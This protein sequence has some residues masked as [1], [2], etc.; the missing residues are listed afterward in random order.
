MPIY[1]QRTVL[2][3]KLDATTTKHL[4]EL[5]RRL[6]IP[7]RGTKAERIRA[8]SEAH[9]AAE[10]IDA[11]IRELYLVQTSVE[12]Q[13]LT[14][15]ELHC[16]LEKLESYEWPCRQGGLDQY[17]QGNITRRYLRYEDVKEAVKRTLTPAVSSYALCSWYNTWST[18]LIEH[19]V[20]Q[21][22]TVVPT[23]K[24]VKGIDIFFRNQPFD[25]KTTLL[26]AQLNDSLD[27]L[28]D[29]P[30]D[31]AIWYFENQG[32]ER[33]G[34]DNR[35]FIVVHDPA[36]PEQSWK[37]KRDIELVERVVNQALSKESVT[38]DDEIVFSYGQQT[39]SAQ[40]KVI[41]I[42]PDLP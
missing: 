23:L 7:T 9:V 8:I 26:P 35:M 19:C 12:L 15:Y 31:L 34:A 3:K 41:F 1:D 6:G 29:N 16:E 13:G 22:P 5:A 25:L 37:L 38:E 20:A 24:N 11:I 28:L 39:Y 30:S 33:F 2:H 32:A 18:W 40:A 10:T 27:E 36:N 21:H 14:P 17:I 42:M 4:E